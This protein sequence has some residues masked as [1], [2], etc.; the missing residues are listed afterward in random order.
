MS[1][2]ES[3]LGSKSALSSEA[4]QQSR[5]LSGQ[6]RRAFSLADDEAALDAFLA[7]A[8][9]G[10]IDPARLGGGLVRLIGWVNS[11]YARFERE[12]L[13]RA[14]A[15][16]PIRQREQELLRAKE[17]AE[18]ANRAKSEF[19]ANMSHEIRTPLNGVLGMTELALDTQLTD[20][21]R[22]YLNTARS[23]ADE[24][25]TVIHDILVV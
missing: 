15:D 19:L 23:S 18:T 25:L 22:E 1:D 6:L 9:A 5:L 3:R 2:A 20:E 11:A 21:Q 12:F 8:V 14:G 7:D 24:L 4:G 17:A 13:E 10:R 16:E